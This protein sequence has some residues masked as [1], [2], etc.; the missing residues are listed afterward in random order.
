M[1]TFQEKIRS[2]QLD[3][4]P[5]EQKKL[6][7]KIT[8]GN[9]SKTMKSKVIFRVHCTLPTALLKGRGV[10][11]VKASASRPKDRGFKPHQGHDHVS[12]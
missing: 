5:N 3:K 12:P 9:N 1:W 11:V 10:L 6:S 8:K 7:M 2:S 4:S